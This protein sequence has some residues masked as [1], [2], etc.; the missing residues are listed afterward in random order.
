MTPGAAGAVLERPAA[1]VVASA[2]WDGPDPA[3]TVLVST[4]KRPTY[5][6]E[7]VG[8]L[9]AQ[10]HDDFEVVLVDNGSGDDSFE[11]LRSIAS[12]TPLRLA[13]LRLERNGGPAGGRNA[14]A[15]HA[16]G[17][18]LAITDDD[19]LPTPGWL[20]G[21]VEAFAD[22]GVHVVQGRVE[23]DPRG[24]DELGPWDH[25]IWVLQPTPFFETCNVSYRRDAFVAA[26][27]FDETDPLLHPPSGRA[28]G[29]DACL[30]WEVQ[31]AGGRAGW[32]E[33]TVQHRCI[34]STFD[35]WLA[36]QRQLERFPGL[37]RRSPL[38]ARW[39]YRGIFLDRRSALFDLAV[40][41]AVAA[42]AGRRP[43]PLLAA[44]PWL[45]LRWTTAR[46]YTKG[47]R[48]P[49]VGLL[50]RFALSDTVALASMVKGTIRYRR[51]LL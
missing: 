37:A 48:E 18:I 26:G 32:T 35:R 3:V 11:V 2:R 44:W 40:V 19:C 1:E 30:A 23:P 5:L 13:A 33:A 38:V 29:E 22:P 36:D 15:A 39:L 45:R 41:G 21:V 34:P 20:T 31:R 8:R 28:F 7:L 43:W 17:S 4:Y 46:R 49:A 47:D 14:G 6:R 16:R 25:T 12:T 42:A 50:L 24:R 9:E 27:G 10:D 51:V